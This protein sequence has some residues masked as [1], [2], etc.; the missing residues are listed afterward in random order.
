MW[1]RVGEQVL[2]Y[3]RQQAQRLITANGSNNYS[4]APHTIYSNTRSVQCSP[5]GS[6]PEPMSAF[7]G[8]SSKLEKYL[9]NNW[10]E[11]TGAKMP[12]GS[13]ESASHDR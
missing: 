9:H 12:A 10:N 13:A 8:P 11:N 4:T 7:T 3:H 1:G 6:C 2:R 5:G